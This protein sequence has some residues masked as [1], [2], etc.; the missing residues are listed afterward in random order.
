MLFHL[1]LDQLALYTHLPYIK[2]LSRLYDDQ[3]TFVHVQMARI[4]VESL[5]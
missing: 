4:P 1:H 5:P 3:L 2:P